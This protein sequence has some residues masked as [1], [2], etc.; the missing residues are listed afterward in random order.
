MKTII[1]FGASSAIAQGYIQHLKSLETQ[2]NII[3]IS[4][5]Q[6]P[7]NESETCFNTDYSAKSLADIIIHVNNQKIELHQVVIF[8]GQLHNS[9]NMPEK[10]LEDINSEYFN[11]L[12]QSNTLTPI[13]CLQS[14]LPLLNHSI[15]CKIIAFSARVGSIE[16]NKLGGW[17]SYRASKAALNMF[18]KTAAIEVARRAKNTKLILFHPGT[19]DTKLSKP[20]QKN[21]NSKKLFTTKFVAEQLY[22]L[23]QQTT[24][25]Q[26]R[27]EHNCEA[28][29]LDW[30][31]KKIAW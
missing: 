19:T 28:S 12:L 11:E 21:I 22:I 24:G 7:D 26:N 20:F 10:K 27:L 2:F 3:C 25:E 23:T 14:I 4:S 30:Q 18:F 1:L 15:E 8:N 6:L 16:D 13:L 29:Y 17:Y 5:S 31:G 9:N